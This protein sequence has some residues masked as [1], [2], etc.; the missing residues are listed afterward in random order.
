MEFVKIKRP[1]QCCSTHACVKDLRY[2]L[3]MHVDNEENMRT[4]DKARW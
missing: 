1:Q 3:C 2:A 4:S